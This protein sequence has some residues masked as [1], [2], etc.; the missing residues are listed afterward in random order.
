MVSFS[1]SVLRTYI[2]GCFLA[3]GGVQQVFIR[4]SWFLASGFY[5]CLSWSWVVSVSAGVIHWYSEVAVLVSG[6]VD[7]T[8]VSLLLVFLASLLLRVLGFYG[9]WCRWV[10]SSWF[11]V[12]R[13]SF[14]GVVSAQYPVLGVEVKDCNGHW[15]YTGSVSRYCF[16]SSSGSVLIFGLS[17]VVGIVCRVVVLGACWFC[18]R[19][20]AVCSASPSDTSSSSASAFLS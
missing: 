20:I 13:C 11:Y 14:S 9:V 6:F 17:G 8:W 18:L 1:G 7:G 16:P 15:F 3:M 10:R 12:F 2:L 5:C 4:C 19:C